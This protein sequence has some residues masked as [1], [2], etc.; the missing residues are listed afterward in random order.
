MRPTCWS[1]GRRTH[2]CAHARAS[3]ARSPQDHKRYDPFSPFNECPPGQP[4]RRYGNAADGGKQL[5]DV[6][7][8]HQ[9][10]LIVSLGSAGDYSFERDMLNATKCGGRA[11]A[12]YVCVTVLRVCCSRMPACRRR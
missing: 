6:G 9:P 10:C 2:A 7:R 5:C 1:A 4:L 8:L 11:A 3:R 12:A